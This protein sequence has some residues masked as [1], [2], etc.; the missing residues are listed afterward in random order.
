MLLIHCPYCL[1]ERPESEFRYGG[2]AHIA[3][4]T[5]PAAVNDAEWGDF[6]YMRSNPKGIHVE[7]WRHIH[8]CGRFFNSV[9]DTVSDRILATY[10]PDEPR[11][12]PEAL[13]RGHRR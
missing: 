8:G 4:P 6:L 2:E 10:K 5:E 1:M 9:R 3:R 11:P 7:R 13:S 12:D